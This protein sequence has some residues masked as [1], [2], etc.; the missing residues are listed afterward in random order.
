MPPPFVRVPF[1]ELPAR[2]APHP[3]FR[4]PEARLAIALPDGGRSTVSLRRFGAGPPLLLLHGLMTTGYSWRRVIEPLSRRFTVL[5]PDLP[6][7]GRTV[8]PEGPL[9]PAR[10]V[11][12]LVALIDALELDHTSVIGNS[13]GGY[14]ALWLALR[15]PARVERLL[16]VHAPGLPEHRL[17]ALRLALRLPGAVRLLRWMVQ[18]EPRR[19]VWR[20]V[21]YW[22][23]G[24]KSLEELEEYGAPLATAAGFEGFVRQLRD[25]M[26]PVEMQRFV[27]LC[28][29]AP[30]GL[31]PVHLLYT[32]RDP[33]VPPSLGPRLQRVVPR[34]TLSFV[35][36]GG[37]FLHVDRPEAF[38][39]AVDAWAPRA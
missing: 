14:L 13:M 11:D 6:G 27:A 19:W 22:D 28:G 20:N 3:F 4:A 31:P 5:V 12:W 8:G 15:A 34:A 9:P 36:E 25:M 1:A 16:V 2:A 35:E 10:V 24:Q 21:H 18:R 29:Q 39:A 38:L 32:R 37:H 17:W 26:D 23:E 33:M 30:P 7:A